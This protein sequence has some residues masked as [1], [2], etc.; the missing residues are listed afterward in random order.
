MDKAIIIILSFILIFVF[1][2]TPVP[3][4][5]ITDEEFSGDAV[6]TFKEKEEV[7]TIDLVLLRVNGNSMFPTI[8]DNSKC[9]CVKKNKYEID[10]I[11]FFFANL[12]NE[13]VGISHRIS[14]IN[15]EEIITKGDNNKF[16][17]PPMTDENIVC[18]IPYVPRYKILN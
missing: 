15:G 18:A 7:K 11:I 2:T 10:D 3:Y 9:L 1:L 14:S 17:D 4:C 6:Y 5:K 13:I 12:N 16:K 8:K